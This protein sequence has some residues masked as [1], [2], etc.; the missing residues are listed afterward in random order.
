MIDLLIKTVLVWFVIF[1]MANIF[2]FGCLIVC[3]KN[4]PAIEKL[5]YRSIENTGRN[6]RAEYYVFD[7]DGKRWWITQTKFDSYKTLERR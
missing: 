2:I 6:G 1:L 5:V 7:I 3:S 4:A